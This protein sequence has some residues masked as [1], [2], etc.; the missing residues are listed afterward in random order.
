MIRAKISGLEVRGFRR[1]QELAPFTFAGPDGNPPDTLVVAGPNGCGKSSFF[2]AILFVLGREDLL[3]RELH[4]DHRS[5]WIREACS[6]DVH[7]RLHLEVSEAAGT[8]L[9]TRAPCSI[10]IA[11]SAS[12]WHVRAGEEENPIS[13]DDGVIRTLLAEIAIEWFSSWRQPY[14]PGPVR[15]MSDVPDFVR[16]EAGCIWQVKQR[17]VDERTRSAF[18]DETGKDVVWLEKLSGAWSALRGDD[19][20]HLSVDCDARDIRQRHFDLYLQRRIESFGNVTICP[21]DQLSS[22]ELQWLALV[23]TLITADFEGIVL[24][25]EP[26]LHMHPEWQSRLL[27]ALRRVVPASQIV[28]ATHADPPWDQ[29][30]SFERVLLVPPDDPRAQER[31]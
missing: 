25:D 19:G 17:I 8:L 4:G 5:R 29:V 2:E 12:G 11:R 6:P 14:L 13:D 24:I 23:G 10:A 28:L 9:G 30:Y 21:I 26:E 18:R 3:H 27:P 15:P 1:F 31:K 16:G 22:G 7:V 20:T